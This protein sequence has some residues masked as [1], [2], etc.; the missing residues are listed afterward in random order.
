MMPKTAGKIERA[1]GM[2][3]GLK[4][5]RCSSPKCPYVRRQSRPGAHGSRRRMLSEL[6]K[7]LLEKQRLR[8]SYGLGEQ[9]FKNYVEKAKTDSKEVGAALL[10][11]LERR[12]DNV[13]FRAGFA[14]SRREARV[15]IRH[16]HFTLNGKIVRSP[17]LLVR[18]GDVASLNPSSQEL[19]TFVQRAKVL[20][21]YNPPAWLEVTA[22]PMTLKVARLPERDELINV[23]YDTRLVVE[24][25]SR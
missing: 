18:P 16:G 15:W 5:Q 3:L 8:V 19:E 4:P 2:N 7:E 21:Q 20:E 14:A 25:Y 12:L 9:A 10:K 13:L 17:S 23:P 1:L 24:Y 22:S 6:G 11:I